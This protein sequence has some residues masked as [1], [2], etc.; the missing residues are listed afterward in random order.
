[1][2]KITTSII[3]VL[4]FLLVGLFAC[5]PKKLSSNYG[6][7]KTYQDEDS[8]QQLKSVEKK[9]KMPFDT[10]SNQFFDTK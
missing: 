9:G 2:N 7:N 1:M 8:V 4:A 10:S 3:F 6:D 5:T